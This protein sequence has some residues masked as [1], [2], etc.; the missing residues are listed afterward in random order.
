MQCSDISGVDGLNLDLISRDNLG[1][2]SRLID[3]EASLELLDALLAC[4]ESLLDSHILAIVLVE[5]RVDK[6]A[7]VAV[8]ALGDLLKSTEIVHPVELGFILD[9]VIATHQHIDLEGV[10]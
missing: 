3:D 6:V 7:G 5:D 9:V 1:D 4:L 10:A 8:G 2:K